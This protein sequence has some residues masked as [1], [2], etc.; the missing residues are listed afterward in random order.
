MKTNTVT[1]NLAFNAQQQNPQEYKNS[2]PNY[3]PQQRG[4]GRSG[5]YRGHGGYSSRGRGF[6]QHQ[7][8]SQNA[9][10]RPVCQICG[11]TGHIALKCHNRFDISYQSQQAFS[12]MKVTDEH[13]REWYPDSGA[14][15]HI[16]SSA[17]NLETAH[18]YEGADAVMVGD[19]AYLPIT[20]VGASNITSSAGTIP[21][22]EVLVCPDIKKSLLSVSKLC[23]DFPCGVFFDVKNVYVIDLCTQ[24]VV[25]KGPRANGLYM[26][27]DA[28]FSTFYSNRQVTASEAVWHQRL[29]H[30]NSRI[31]QHLQASKDIYSE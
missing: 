3:N 10:E 31:L 18:P 30:A 14:T 28:E 9:G 22:N 19:G 12:T 5:Y 2:A 1:P 21:L 11:R 27:K 8:Q 7:T 20:H 23:E 24:K 26:L 16:T 17:Q 15:A 13:G 29:G 25:S 4:R 6:V